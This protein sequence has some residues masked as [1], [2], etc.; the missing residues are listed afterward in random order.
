MA[1]LFWLNVLSELFFI[2]AAY[3]YYLLLNTHYLKGNKN[4]IIR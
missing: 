3:C 2:V 1:P 4:A